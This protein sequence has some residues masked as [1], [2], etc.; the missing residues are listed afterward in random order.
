[1]FASDRLAKLDTWKCVCQ[2]ISVTLFSLYFKLHQ[3]F[4]QGKGHLPPLGYAEISILY[5]CKSLI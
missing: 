4:F 3:G 5:I 2:L 1:M